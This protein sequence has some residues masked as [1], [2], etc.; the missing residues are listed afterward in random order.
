MKRK[1]VLLAFASL[2]LAATAQ[3]AAE[4]GYGKKAGLLKYLP[5]NA[6]FGTLVA[7][8]EASRQVQRSFCR[9]L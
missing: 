6:L 3:T 4:A 7:I 8:T 2:G 5:D 1:L 9:L